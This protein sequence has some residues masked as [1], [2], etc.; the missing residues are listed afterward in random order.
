MQV[1]SPSTAIVPPLLHPTRVHH[2]WPRFFLC[3][4][5]RH[6]LHHVL[7]SCVMG[8]RQVLHV[9]LKLL[10]AKVGLETAVETAWEDTGWE[11][12]LSPRDR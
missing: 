10:H 12:L 8:R 7:M 5:L 4:Y 6:V 3:T 2:G 1:I 9:Y 11:R